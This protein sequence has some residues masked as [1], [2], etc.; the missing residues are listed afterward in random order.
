MKLQSLEVEPTSLGRVSGHSVVH[1]DRE[2][3]RFLQHARGDNAGYHVAS[4][5]GVQLVFKRHQGRDLLVVPR[6][7]RQLLLD[8]AHG[9]GLAAHFGAKKMTKLL[10]TRVWWPR[11]RD[12]CRKT[13]N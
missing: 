11:L 2:M 10:G 9:S 8:E 3:Q 13:C 4:K 7:C 5:H 6:D 12:A 1:Q